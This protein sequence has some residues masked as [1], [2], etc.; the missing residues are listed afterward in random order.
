MK[1]IGYLALAFLIIGCIK[2]DCP[3]YPEEFM[4]WMPYN[5]DE[6]LYFISGIDSLKLTI[7]D[8]YRSG[9]HI[10]RS[11]FFK[12]YCRIEARVAILNE[13]AAEVICQNSIYNEEAEQVTYDL[14]L[15]NY[16]SFASFQI[17]NGKITTGLGQLP[18][19]LLNEYN[20]GFKNYSNVLIINIDTLN[21][22]LS[23][24]YQI[25]IAESIGIIQ[26]NEGKNH[27]KWCLI[28]K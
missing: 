18:T 22:N 16:T 5:N 21:Y 20:N 6:N 15:F 28:G 25:Y 12:E 24:V 8:T 1:T 14:N 17:K 26:I 4:K 27:K 3:A 9:P 23:S 13:S 19:N 10:A 2:Y 7:G 11:R